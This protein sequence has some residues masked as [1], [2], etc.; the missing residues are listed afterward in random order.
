MHQVQHVANGAKDSDT[1]NMKTEILKLIPEMYLPD[2]GAEGIIKKVAAAYFRDDPHPETSKIWR[3]LNNPITTRLLCP[4]K[5]IE[6]LKKDPEGYVGWPDCHI[7][8]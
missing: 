8:V 1:K 3:G 6:Q 2:T 7:S 4:A 5:Y